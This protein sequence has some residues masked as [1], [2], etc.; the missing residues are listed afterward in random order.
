MEFKVS[1]KTGEVSFSIQKKLYALELVQGAAY[2]LTDRAVDYVEEA[3]GRYELT[4]KAKDKADATRERLEALAGEFV[5]EL[6]NH[7]LRQKLLANNR[8]IMEH[9]ISR[10]MVSARRDPADPAQP[11]AAAEQELNAEQRAE[12]DKLIAEAEAEIAARRKATAK[13]D[14]RGIAKTWEERYGKERT[15]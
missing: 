4:L 13:P 8:S 11:P 2:V 14:P 1:T 3:K 15:G 9:I 6:L 7:A 10:A 12:I 5:N